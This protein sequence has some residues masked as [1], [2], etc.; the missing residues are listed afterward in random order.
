VSEDEMVNC[1]F[2]HMSLARSPDGQWVD[3]TSSTLCDNPTHMHHP[4]G[5]SAEKAAEAAM[6]TDLGLAQMVLPADT[7]MFVIA[8]ASGEFYSTVSQLVPNGLP[9]EHAIRMLRSIAE[10][11][12]QDL[13][14]EIAQ[15]N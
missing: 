6:T 7:V 1:H 9:K 10:G 12:E 13:I 11:W 15:S 14:N 3:R 4:T 5:E 8:I 2:C